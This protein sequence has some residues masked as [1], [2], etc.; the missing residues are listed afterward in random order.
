MIELREKM[1]KIKRDNCKSRDEEKVKEYYRLEREYKDH[2]LVKEYESSKEEI[3]DLLKEV[4][5]I[6]SF[7]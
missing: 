2:I 7:I 1:E 5:D 4:S 3:Y 6:L